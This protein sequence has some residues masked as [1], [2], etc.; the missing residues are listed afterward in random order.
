MTTADGRSTAMVTDDTFLDIDYAFSEYFM[1]VSEVE[2]ITGLK[3]SIEIVEDL[4]RL[5]VFIMTINFKD[6][7]D[8]IKFDVTGTNIKKQVIYENIQRLRPNLVI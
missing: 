8:T 2:S 1:L 3:N 6:I 4:T 5:G 7:D